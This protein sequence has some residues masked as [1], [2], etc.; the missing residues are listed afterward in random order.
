M[1]A[2]LKPDLEA[3]IVSKLQRYIEITIAL[4]SNYFAIEEGEQVNSS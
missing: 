1:E 3:I 4:F 2:T